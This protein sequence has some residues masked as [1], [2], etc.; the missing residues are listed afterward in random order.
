MDNWPKFGIFKACLALKQ[1]LCTVSVKQKHLYV[2]ES[3]TFV[4][5]SDKLHHLIHLCLYFETNRSL[6]VLFH[7]LCV[8]RPKMTF[9][10]FLC[11]MS[12]SMTDAYYS[13]TY[14]TSM[15]KDLECQPTQ[16]AKGATNFYLYIK[17]QSFLSTASLSWLGQ[18]DVWE[19]A[20]LT[21][22]KIT[23]AQKY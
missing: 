20:K 22:S 19:W 17:T 10:S 7:W 3:C 21:H 8:L 12:L 1:E 16:L 4:L 5:L 9:E 11:Q 2:C 18:N 14:K 13:L 6:L 15:N 23:R